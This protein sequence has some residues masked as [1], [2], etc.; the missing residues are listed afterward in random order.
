MS[1]HA[2]VVALKPSGYFMYCTTS[3]TIKNFTF[4]PHSA[5]VLHASKKKTAIISLHGVNLL[6]FI[7]ETECVYY[8]VW[9]EALNIIRVSFILGRVKHHSIKTCVP[10]GIDPHIL[11][12]GT[13]W[14]LLNLSYG[15]FI[16]R[17]K[18]PLVHSSQKRPE[19]TP[20][21]FRSLGELLPPLTAPWQ[22][23]ATRRILQHC[24]LLSSA[25]PSSWFSLASGAPHVIFFVVSRR[26]GLLKKP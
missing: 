1:G 9:T 23:S 15:C 25:F 17:K 3:F 21:L 10:G 12:L 4:C 20:E 19:W 7:T 18:E 22:T 6:V 8:A 16:H 13:K 11:K 14:E 26:W 2:K 24:N 5:L